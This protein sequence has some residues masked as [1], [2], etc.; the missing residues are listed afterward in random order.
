MNSFVYWIYDDSCSDVLTEGYVG[1]TKD[2]ENRVKSHLRKNRVPSDSTY[3]ILFEGTREECFN[4]E[5]QLRPTKN[6]GWNNAIGGSHGWRVGFSHSEETK[7]KLK[8]KWTDERKSTAS[9][10]KAQQNKKLIGQK[11]LKQS[12]AMTGSKNPMFG[13]TRPDH[14]KD[15]VR[16]AHLGKEPANKQNNYCPL[17]GKRV[18]LSVMKKYHG[19]NKKA[20]II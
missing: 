11:R 6:I 7:Q 4:Y 19:P 15:A 10:F 1:V 2:V 3:K 9:I 20:C 8:S 18:S 17:C 14:V 12:E 5:R 16:S 13:T